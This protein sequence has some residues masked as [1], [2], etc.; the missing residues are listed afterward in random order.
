MDR[1]DSS[2]EAQRAE[3]LIGDIES[4]VRRIHGVAVKTPLLESPLLNARAGGRVL[5]KAETLQRTGS[6]KFRG[7]YNF[8]SQID[9]AVRPRGVASFSSGNHAQGVAQAAQ[10]H[11]IPATIVMPADAPAI[12]QRNTEFYGATV[13]TYERDGEDRQ[14]ITQRIIEETGGTLVPPYDHPWIVAGQGTVGLEIA[15]QTA[16]A[17]ARPD[18]VLVPCGGGGLVAGVAIALADRMPET[19]VYAVEPE[20]HNDTKRSLESGRRLPVEA[21]RASFCDA[22]LAPIPGELTFQVNARLLAGGLAVG[23]RAVAQAML[24]LFEDTKLVAEPGGAVAMAAVLS[25]ALQLN[26]GTAVVVCSGGNVDAA[27][28]ARALEDGVGR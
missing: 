11:G 16:E 21:D 1:M 20:S 28:F 9:P 22:L 4:A 5:I 26:G 2:I 19:E 27:V 6:F 14:A 15:E 7:A 25:G 10:L 17:D 12:K 13:V 18:T 24:A 8:I 23:D 3:P